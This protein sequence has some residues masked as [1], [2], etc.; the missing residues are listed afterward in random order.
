[1][2]AGV[3]EVDAASVP[4]QQLGAELVFQARELLAERRLGE[5]EPRG[6]PG[7]GPLLRDGHEVPELP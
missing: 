6:G 7:D 4:D 1:V 5:V 2:R 3:G